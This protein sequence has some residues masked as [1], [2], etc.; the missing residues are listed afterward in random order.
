[1]GHTP[2]LEETHEQPRWPL[3]WPLERVGTQSSGQREIGEEEE[4]HV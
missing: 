2:Y 1:M 3:T 4:S